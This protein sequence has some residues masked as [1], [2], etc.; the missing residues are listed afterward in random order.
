MPVVITDFTPV[1]RLK[2]GHN[3]LV[4]TH[5]ATSKVIINGQNLEDDM[6]VDVRYP[7]GSANPT[8]HWTGTTYDTDAGGTQTWAKLKQVRVMLYDD[9]TT[10]SVTVDDSA[11][12]NQQAYTGTT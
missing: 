5:G 4:K 9:L 7:A 11:P 8:Y 1:T 12:V 3:G 10:V 6:P 2:D